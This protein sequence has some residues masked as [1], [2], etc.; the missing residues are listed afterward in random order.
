MPFGNLELLRPDAGERGET[1]AQRVHAR[2]LRLHLPQLHGH[3]IEVLLQEHAL[4]LGFG[5]LRGGDQFLQRGQLDLGGV[6]QSEP[7]ERGGGAEQKDKREQSRANQ[8][9]QRHMH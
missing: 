6:T 7:V 4:A 8:M 3:R 1:L 2:E 9:A 5:L